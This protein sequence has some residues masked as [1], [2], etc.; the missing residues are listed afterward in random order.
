M[1]AV[2]EEFFDLCAR[3]VYQTTI[4]TVVLEEIARADSPKRER[5]AELVRTISPSISTLTPQAVSLANKFVSMNAV[6]PSKPEDAAHV[7][8]AFASGAEILVSW[9]FKHIASVRRAEKFNAIASL[10]GYRRPLTITTPGELL[11]AEELP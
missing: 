5:L 8:C 9:N 1:R 11:D 7:A 2:T 10:F 6:P 4:S 3:N